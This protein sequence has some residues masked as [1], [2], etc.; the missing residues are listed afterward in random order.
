MAQTKSLSHHERRINM[1]YRAEL[2]RMLDEVVRSFGHE[3]R[4]AIRLATII[5]KVYDNCDEAGLK[6][7]K[8]VYESLMKKS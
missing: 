4:E 6:A 5:D 3:S 1:N 7:V 2:D 8:K